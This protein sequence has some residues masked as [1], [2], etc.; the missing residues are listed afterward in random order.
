MW[1]IADLR[2]L[3][4]A[5]VGLVPTALSAIA[6]DDPFPASANLKRSDPGRPNNAIARPEIRSR[7]SALGTMVSYDSR[8]DNFSPQVGELV[9]ASWMLRLR[10]LGNDVTH[11]RFTLAAS[12][13]RPVGNKTVLAARAS[14]CGV[15]AGAP[16]YDLCF[17]GTNND[18]RGYE[19]G[20]YGGGA[21][22]AA[23]A[24]LR[25]PLSER[26][27]ATFFAGI[28]GV[29]PGLGQLTQSRLLPAAG[30]G[31]SFKPSSKNDIKLRADF[32][33]GRDGSTF[34]LSLGDAF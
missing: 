26:V 23:Q 19:I 10:P 20:S 13:Y 34:Y 33:M 1:G 8:D 21:S 4:A 24:E 15:S 14:V 2:L 5:W 9:N 12:L 17:W 28:G 32:A 25:H 3:L 7:R 31:L 27:G 18:L 30:A 6:P 11:D 22:W 16:T 29:A